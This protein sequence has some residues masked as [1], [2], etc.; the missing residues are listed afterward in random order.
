MNTRCS[1]ATSCSRA[2]MD[3]VAGTNIGTL[4]L[5]IPFSA[6]VGLFAAAIPQRTG[7]LRCSSPDSAL[8]PVAQGAF[9]EL[10]IHR[11]LGHAS[12]PRAAKSQRLCLEFR[13]EHSSLLLCHWTL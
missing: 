12:A 3:R 10:K 13:A 4:W 6:I 8:F 2:T 1:H 7:V 11:Y 9:C 5:L